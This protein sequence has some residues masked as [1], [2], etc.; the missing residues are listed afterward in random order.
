MIVAKDSYRN[1][2]MMLTTGILA[3]VQ[4]TKLVHFSEDFILKDNE[5][6][7]AFVIL[8]NRLGKKALKVSK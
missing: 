1:I 7:K 8:Q 2:Y 3:L 4:I 5:K 6:V